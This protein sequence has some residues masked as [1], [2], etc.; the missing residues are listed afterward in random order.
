MCRT[1]GIF[2]LCRYF[3]R[4][5][6]RILCYHGFTRGEESRWQSGI[7]MQAATLM[8]RMEYVKASGYTVLDLEEAVEKMKSGALPAYSVVITV[9][10][11]FRNTESI[12]HPIFASHAIPYTVYLTTYY[13]DKDVPIVNLV[14]P[15]AMWKAEKIKTDMTAFGINRIF[16]LADK[17]ERKKLFELAFAMIDKIK[18][19][20]AK[21]EKLSLFLECLGLDAGD[22]LSREE[23]KLLTSSQVKKLAEAGVDFQLHTHRHRFPSSDQ[24]LLD[25]L[26]SNSEWLFSVTGKKP[27]HLCYPSGEYRLTALPLLENFGIR[28]ATTCMEGLNDSSTNPLLLK[29]FLDAEDIHPLEF[30]AYL[31]GF[32]SFL[33]R[34]VY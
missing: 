16:D 29:R 19:I 8:A 4:A 14:I 7:M 5:K 15:F 22:I 1:C 18:D 10:D 11:G 31:S 32:T 27:A 20:P 30:E 23:I 24:L 21:K 2:A 12:A 9:D 6:L 3:S 17:E 34:I 28:S 13:C 25:E 26:V 33:K